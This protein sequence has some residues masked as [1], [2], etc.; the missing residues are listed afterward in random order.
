M[1]Q[2]IIVTG[3]NRGLGLELTRQLSRTGHEV[4]ATVRKVDEADHLADLAHEIHEL[5]VTRPESVAAFAASIK[6]RPIDVLINNAALGGVLEQHDLEKMLDYFNVNALGPLRLVRAVLPNLRAGQ[7]KLIVNISSKMGSIEANQSG[8]SYGYRA[9]K[10]AL[11]MITKNLALELEGDGFTSVVIHPG[12]VKTD[13]GGPNAQ[14]TVEESV[15]S[16]LGVIGQ[17]SEKDNGSFLDL[18][19]TMLPW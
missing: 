5:E 17:L 16:V 6:G 2:T 10:A 13:M 12:W 14:I 11:N 8:G 7:R 19:G 18:D 15:A 1:N 9:S 4:I 3:A